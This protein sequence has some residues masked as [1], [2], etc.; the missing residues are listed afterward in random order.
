[1]SFNWRVPTVPGQGNEVPAATE[2]PGDRADRR[3]RRVRAPSRRGASGGNPLAPV[4][5]FEVG[6]VI[7]GKYIIERVIGTWGAGRLVVAAKH[8]ALEQ[9]VAIK[10]LLPAAQMGAEPSSERFIREARLAASI[11]SEHVARVYDVATHECGVPYIVMEYL[12]GRD[13][14]SLVKEGP[15]PMSDAVDFLLQACEA[16]A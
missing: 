8:I 11:K 9:S 5:A 15:I 1:M 2:T 6:N 13:L 16:L 12:V 4:P 3:L 14:R 7:A 10:Y